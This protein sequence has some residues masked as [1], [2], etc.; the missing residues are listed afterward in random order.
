MTF[1]PIV[2]RE[3]RVAARRKTT[4]R[5]RFLAAVG[6]TLLGGL[7][8]AAQ[9]LPGG[10]TP[11]GRPLFSLLVFLQFGFALLSGPML[12]ADC[13][14]RERREGTLGFLFLTD[15]RGF[16]VVAGK[17]AALGLL[18]LHGLLSVFPITAI[19]LLLGGVSGGEFWRAHAVVLNT[20]FLSLAAGLWISSVVTDERQSVALTLG[21]VATLTAAPLL[22]TWLL[23]LSPFATAGQI[24]GW[25]S[26]VTTLVSAA[27]SPGGGSP[28][29]FGPALLYQHALGWIF[30][31][32]AA[33]IVRGSW[34][35]DPSRGSPRTGGEPAETRTVA[36]PERARDFAGHRIE[37]LRRSG[38]LALVAWRGSWIRHAIPWTTGLFAGLSLLVF[39]LIARGPSASDAD[40]AADAATFTLGIGLFLLK[41]LAVVHSAYFL[42]DL[43][44]SGAMELILTTPVSSQSLRQGHFAALREMFLRPA[45]LLV[46]LQIG[47]GL[48][49]RWIAG[50]DWPNRTTLILAAVTPPAFG[51]LTHF[52][53]FLAV[54]FHVSTHALRYDKPSKAIARS[55]VSV[56]LLPLIFCSWGRIVIDVILIGQHTTRLDRFRELAQGWFFPSRVDL[57]FSAPRR[58]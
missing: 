27:S 16:D 10:F 2:E 14:S 17:F 3:L 51:A 18:P 20:L 34:R 22:L 32:L 56:L 42:H 48:A 13:L 38:P 25:A 12:T 7:F 44:R 33:S 47:F 29:G 35:S 54:S 45:L 52:A 5:I 36:S 23:V 46:L 57:N 19:T 58:G 49:G 4:F 50:G 53:E 30:L 9:Q 43:C 41:F 37:R 15:L 40:A 1:L 24:V 11:S 31:I 55:V 8:L 26:P 6:M 21:V 28:P 39:G